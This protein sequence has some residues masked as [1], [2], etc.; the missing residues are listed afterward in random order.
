MS[1]ETVK[2][3]RAYIGKEYQ[4]GPQLVDPERIRQFSL[5]TNEKNP[6]HL[7]AESDI[8]IVPT[9]IYP[10]V[11]LPPILS[12]LVDD[13]EEM[14]LNILRAVHAEH[15]M[16]WKEILHPGDQINTI[17]RISLMEQLGINEVLGME[18]RLMRGDVT[19]VEMDYRLIIRG[20][21]KKGKEKPASVTP[22]PEKRNVLAKGTSVV[23]EDQGVRYAQASGDHN[24]IHTSDE[25]AKSV[26]LPGTILHGLCTMS[27]ASQV[28]VEELMDG[29]S[30]RLKSMEVRFSS[31][32]FMDQI[33]TTEIYSGASKDEGRVH[34]ETRD[35]RNVPVLVHG[36]AEFME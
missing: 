15:K 16:T 24:P 34:F 31:P 26:G 25:I 4:T 30:K 21:K 18:I 28:L 33:L 13:G 29:D 3:N 23:T 11:F 12:Q 9:P 17:A 1:D 14:G 10:V 32:V 5:A 6:R 20:E 19:V 36:I 2:L 7:N 35:A 8:E 27:L 22:E